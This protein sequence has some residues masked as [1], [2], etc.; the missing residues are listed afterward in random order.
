MDYSIEE[1]HTMSGIDPWFLK[2]LKEIVDF[3]K[4]IS[5]KEF[6]DNK[7]EFYKAKKM[8]FSDKKISLIRNEKEED[9]RKARKS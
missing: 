2:E 8:G 1:L 5:H 3:E 4:N 7:E 6:L 9:I